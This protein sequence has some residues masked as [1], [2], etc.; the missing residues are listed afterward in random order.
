MCW[1]QRAD[2]GTCLSS[3]VAI[4]KPLPHLQ[5]FVFR[6]CSSVSKYF[7]VKFSHVLK[8]LTL[9]LILWM[10]LSTTAHYFSMLRGKDSVL[11]LNALWLLAYSVLGNTLHSRQEQKRDRDERLQKS[12]EPALSCTWSCQ[13]AW[14]AHK[15]NWVAIWGSFIIKCQVKCNQ[16]KGGALED[17]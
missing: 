6:K 16:P 17:V 12:H 8:I 11:L 9:L 10:L 14:Q 3:I 2:H 13:S 15:N 1:P 7:F 5:W 4:S